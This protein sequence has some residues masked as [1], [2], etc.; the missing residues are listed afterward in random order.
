MTE[1]ILVAKNLDGMREG[2]RF[3]AA[4]LAAEVGSTFALLRRSLGLGA[5]R[6][7][8]RRSLLRFE[9]PLPPARR[10]R[11]RPAPGHGLAKP[12]C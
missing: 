5:L 12:T 9:P 7:L 11:P 2:T 8:E 6:E 3:H 1:P 10:R 4:A